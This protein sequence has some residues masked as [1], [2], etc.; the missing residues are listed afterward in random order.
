MVEKIPNPYPTRP[1]TP[2]S[3]PKTTPY[4]RQGLNWIHNLLANKVLSNEVLLNEVLLKALIMT[5]YRNP[6][7]ANFYQYC[8]FIKV[9]LS[10]IF[11]YTNLTS[12][13]EF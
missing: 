6:Q 7:K 9:L 4:Y 3:T 11:I 1:A 5:F 8:I 12:E 10:D 2:Q 13:M